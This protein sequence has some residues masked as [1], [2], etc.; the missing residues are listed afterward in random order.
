VCNYFFSL[1]TDFAFFIGFWPFYSQVAKWF[2]N[3][4]IVPVPVL[5]K[6]K[7]TLAVVTPLAAKGYHINHLNFIKHYRKQ[8]CTYKFNQ[9][10]NLLQLLVNLKVHATDTGTLWK[11]KH[12][13]VSG[14]PKNQSQCRQ[15]VPVCLHFSH[16]VKLFGGL[17]RYLFCLMLV[18]VYR[19]HYIALLYCRHFM[20]FI[21]PCKKRNCWSD[22]FC[23]VR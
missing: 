23:R 3:R 6:K 7:S 13:N 1:L 21:L 22:F 19:Y 14:I 5:V 20:C 10:L 15:L 9:Y 11:F 8:L 4:N 18:T 16:R 12:W 17:Y 2:T